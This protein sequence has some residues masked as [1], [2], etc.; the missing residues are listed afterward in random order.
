MPIAQYSPSANL[1]K[2]VISGG[3]VGFASPAA[4]LQA[5][6]G[7][8]QPVQPVSGTQDVE[9]PR[10]IDYVFGINA[11]LTP[12][13]GYG[14]MPFTQIKQA[15]ELVTECK[16]PVWL[17]I[18]EMSSFVPRLVDLDGKGVDDHPMQWLCEKPDGKTP[19]SVWLTPF[20]ETTKIYDA[21]AVYLG[22]DRNGDISSV[23]Y[24]DGSTIFVIVDQFG[25]IPAPEP[26]Y[27]YAKRISE[28][29]VSSKKVS[30]PGATHG[31]SSLEEFIDSY[32]KRQADGLDVP[33]KVP[34]FAQ[35]IK[36]TPFSWWS[37]DQ[38]WY[39]PQLKRVDAPYGQSF[40]EAAWPWVNL[41]ANITSFELAHYRTG[42]MPEGILT[43]PQDW[44]TNPDQ[45][46]QAEREMNEHFTTDPV[47]SRNRIRIAPHDSHFEQLKKADF[48]VK[49]YDQ[50]W[51]NILHA[52]GIPPS[53][54][55]DVPGSGLGG[56]GF[57]EGAV[58]DLSRNTLNPQR[59]FVASLFNE[60]L[61]RNGVDDVKFTLDYP[62]EEIDPDKLM[63]N[64][65]QGM[66]H[67]TLSLND[68]LG[69]LNL[70]SV[71]DPADPNNIANKHMIIAGS[72]IYV[73]E[74]MQT[75]GGMAVPTFS[76]QPGGKT[77]GEPV[78][79]ETIAAQAGAEHTP[80]DMHTLRGAIQNIMQ[81]GKLTNKFISIPPLEKY[82]PNQPRDEKGR[83][84]AGGGAAGGAQ[85]PVKGKIDAVK[86]PDLRLLHP[87][88]EETDD[89][90]AFEARAAPIKA[91]VLAHVQRLERQRREDALAPV[92]PPPPPARKGPPVPPVVLPLVGGFDVTATTEVAKMSPLEKH[93]GVCPEDDEYFGAPIARE[94]KLVFPINHHANGVEIVAMCPDG[95][96]AKTALWKPEGGEELSLREFIGGPLYVR[97]EAAYLLDRSLGFNL[98]P[99]AYVAEADDEYGA[100][101]Y[102]TH[103]APPGREATS[104][105]PDWIERAAV[106]DYII[107]QQDRGANGHNYLTHPDDETR[108]VL[109]D[110]GLSF[111]SPGSSV[112]RSGFVSGYVNQPLSS[113]T[114]GA[115][116]T[117]KGDAA[118]WH[119]IQRLVGPDAVFAAR[120]CLQ[121]LIDHGMIL[122]VD[123]SDDETS[124]SSGL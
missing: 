114:L 44:I 59:E 30:I 60:I 98:V 18:R 36:G 9:I 20:L 77:G 66:I 40:I 118:T 28:Q 97:E 16:L 11:T 70:S 6:Y 39:R 84:A 23:H 101:L 51:K 37:S 4:W 91:Q 31:P 80:E 56:K 52:I 22:Q 102:Y 61:A 82:N 54:F 29:G 15:Y 46:K 76:G 64:A 10:S 117:C 26:I 57:K 62:T 99:V 45:L 96:P 13:T 1:R 69:Q 103:D 92:K 2:A 94:L 74:D 42:N 120:Q 14:L 116:T 55:G 17:I 87:D 106:L 100:V 25:N 121:H 3:G 12:R 38:I 43:F 68:A 109:I 113:A 86:A 90:A 110:N 71:G 107:G 73:I 105:G 65:Y 95:L 49:L 50:A 47:T 53:E 108:P 123:D 78:S 119:D 58:S 124:G 27:S 8:G 19:F 72:A 7:P 83:F 88:I 35:I 85:A 34:A 48:P 122:V 67:G 63:D 115:L 104:Y 24:I 33:D 93:C 41:I 89:A 81:H 21:P 75:S 32:L 111:P 112:C 79:P 5:T